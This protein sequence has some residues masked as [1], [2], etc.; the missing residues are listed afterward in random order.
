M[1][2]N[3]GFGFRA[4]LDIQGMKPFAAQEFFECFHGRPVQDALFDMEIEL[5]EK[6]RV[7]DEYD[8]AI[9]AQS[10]TVEPKLMWENEG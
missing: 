10:R 8:Q 3:G 5:P 1:K 9:G 4:T 6:E 2:Q 7:F